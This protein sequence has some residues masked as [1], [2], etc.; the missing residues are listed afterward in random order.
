MIPGM[1]ISSSET[2]WYMNSV[3]RTSRIIAVV[4]TIT[5]AI[6]A[7]APRVAKGI[8]AMSEKVRLM[9]PAAIP[10]AYQNP[11]STMQ[12]STTTML[13]QYMNFAGPVPTW[14]TAIWLSLVNP[15]VALFEEY[16]VSESG[17]KSVLR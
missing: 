5:L 8:A 15:E 12:P 14:E 9:D 4:Y 3:T 1:P 16:I 6:A 7:M 17:P 13:P 11:S 10:I 2:N